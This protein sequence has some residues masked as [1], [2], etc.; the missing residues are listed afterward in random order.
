MDGEKVTSALSPTP[1][2][3][4]RCDVLCGAGHETTYHPG[5]V[6]FRLVVAK[7]YPDYETAA[8]KKGKMR[9]S[10]TILAE[11][12]GTGARFLKKNP[13]Q[14]T[15]WHVADI[16]V[17]K[18]KISHCLRSLK[19]SPHHLMMMN[20][21]D[22]ELDNDSTHHHNSEVRGS[23]I[24]PPIMAASTKTVFVAA[25]DTGISNH[26]LT[27]P[28]P[29]P[30]YC[31]DDSGRTVDTSIP[32][33]QAAAIPD[34]ESSVTSSSRDA[35]QQRTSRRIRRRQGPDND[36]VVAAGRPYY[37]PGYH[38]PQQ[39]QQHHP[40]SPAWNGYYYQYAPSHVPPYRPV[41]GGGP[42]MAAGYGPY[43]TAGPSNTARDIEVYPHSQERPS[44]SVNDMPHYYSEQY[45]Y[46]P[47]QQQLPY[48]EEP[49]TH[50]H[51]EITKVGSSNDGGVSYDHHPAYR[52][53]ARHQEPVTR[54]SSFGSYHYDPSDRS[55]RSAAI[56][57]GHEHDRDWENRSSSGRD[58]YDTVGVST[59]GTDDV[60]HSALEHPQGGPQ[61]GAV[62]D[63]PYYRHEYRTSSRRGRVAASGEYGADY[64][65]YHSYYQSLSQPPSY[66]QYYN[67]GSSPYY[68][69]PVPPPND[70]IPAYHHDKYGAHSTAVATQAPSMA[71]TPTDHHRRRNSAGSTFWDDGW[72]DD[73]NAKTP[74]NMDNPYHHR[75]P[76]MSRQSAAATTNNSRK[77]SWNQTRDSLPESPR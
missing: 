69:P 54:S 20:R 45:Y 39:Y 14:S 55:R 26:G 12:L 31:Y 44:A 75:Y 8:C 74:T 10:R 29:P 43:A 63:H 37:H 22:G 40:Q 13:L 68:Y 21:H 67:D 42:T 53:D 38:H 70:A 33:H 25:S 51:P 65:H 32:L 9:V 27:Q 34:D 73:P 59:T 41:G 23:S 46:P 50:H 4:S 47:Q 64:R 28:Q 72:D 6:K 76:T 30:P 16:K 2:E 60:D 56:F 52:H 5:N 18:D 66:P 7:H 3:P 58:R 24:S 11:V 48:S 36:E 57:R 62:A 35:P 61:E 77:R 15:E 49:P 71:T 19:S 1:V 17:G